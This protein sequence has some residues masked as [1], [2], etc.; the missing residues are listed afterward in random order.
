MVW[1][2]LLNTDEMTSSC[3]VSRVKK[4]QEFSLK[5]NEDLMIGLWCCC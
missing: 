3:K 2:T 4:Y 5:E 1:Y